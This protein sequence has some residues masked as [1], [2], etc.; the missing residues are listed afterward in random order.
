MGNYVLVCT[1]LAPRFLQNN[2][3]RKLSEEQKQDLEKLIEYDEIKDSLKMMPNLKA[4][5][6][7]GL[8]TEIWKH[9]NEL[10]EK[11]AVKDLEDNQP[12][13]V[14][15]MLLTVFND[16]EDKGIEEGSDFTKGWL[17]P[18]FKKK[19]RTDIANYRPITVLNTD[20]KLFTRT[21]TSRIAKKVLDII[22]PDQAGFMIGR[23]IDDHTELI[24]LMIDWCETE[25][26][27]GL[28]VFLD[29][30]KA[31]DRIRH[32]FLCESLDK[33]NFPPKFIETVKLL[34]NDA[35]TV[36]IINGDISKP[37]KV[38]RGVRQGDPLSCLLF[39]MV[40]ES[41]AQSIRNSSLE[42]FETPGHLGNLLVTLFADNTT[43]YLSKND[44][45]NEL[46][47]ILEEW[48]LASGAKFNIDKTEL[49][50]IGPREHRDRIIETR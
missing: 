17:C 26:K 22:H 16:I 14:V 47:I 25:E 12:F 42:G 32:D 33:M 37:F 49:L 6:L 3:E 13:D 39:N 50:P 23:K 35:E 24:K 5:G 29:Q 11:E 40:I 18:I 4:P 1:Y 8:P 2:L 44:S 20:Y 45:F 19:D 7:D 30:E 21:L 28:L 48:C 46:N 10:Y 38:K 36:V 31:Y 27:D 15:A 41:L 34:Y 9:L 43:I